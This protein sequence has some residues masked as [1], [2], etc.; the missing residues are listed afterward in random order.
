M[1]RITVI[2]FQ[3]LVIDATGLAQA[4]VK[5]PKVAIFVDPVVTASKYDLVA[6]QVLYYIEYDL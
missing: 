3:Y 2:K 4:L 1:R 5:G 6:I